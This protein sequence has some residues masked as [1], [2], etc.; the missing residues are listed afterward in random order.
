MLCARVHGCVHVDATSRRACAPACM[1]QR[2][3]E[4]TAYL[5]RHE[6]GNHLRAL[7]VALARHQPRAPAALLA[8]LQQLVERDA[9]LRSAASAGGSGSA[10]QGQPADPSSRATLL[11]Y[12]EFLVGAAPRA[13]QPQ[14]E[15]TAYIEQHKI[16][17]ALCALSRTM[18]VHQPRNPADFFRAAQQLIER[19][20]RE[21]A[22]VAEVVAGRWVKVTAACASEG[23]DAPDVPEGALGKVVEID[24]DDGAACVDFAG[25]GK[26]RLP[27]TCFANFAFLSEKDVLECASPRRQQWVLE[28]IEKEALEAKAKAK[29]AAEAKAREQAVRKAEKAHAERL[30]RLAE[31]WAALGGA[32]VALQPCKPLRERI[33]LGARRHERGEWK[34]L[35]SAPTTLHEQRR[36]TELDLKILRG[37]ITADVRVYVL[38]QDK[39]IVSFL[40][41]STFTDTEWERNLLIDD[42]VPYLQDLHASTASSSASQRCAGVI[43]LCRLVVL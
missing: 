30:A 22:H 35:L 33:G 28:W 10:A 13:P 41:S 8:A 3:E 7:T 26:H 4:H 17:D 39:R 6:L 12:L 5:Q 21:E 18:A 36:D 16:R 42:V 25:L 15:P 11:A 31:E 43:L 23:E 9:L 1:L 40:L 14:Q 34:T 29:K 20:A 2:R 38:Q 37:D 32:S 24:G 19:G 27:T